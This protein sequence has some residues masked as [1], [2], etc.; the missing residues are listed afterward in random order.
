[1]PGKS[2]STPAGVTFGASF[3]AASNQS[4][5]SNVPLRSILGGM[6]IDDDLTGVIN[7]L[8]N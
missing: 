1:M 6:V 3:G 2:S 5:A 7:Q 8:D 4:M